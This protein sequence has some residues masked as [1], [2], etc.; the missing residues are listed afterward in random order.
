LNSEAEIE[1]VRRF[2]SGKD[3]YYWF[4]VRDSEGSGWIYGEF[5]K[6]EAGGN[7]VLPRSPANTGEP[8][9]NSAAETVINTSP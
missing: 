6:P 9:V 4:G 8:D 7:E 1:L 2:S 3:P 5:I